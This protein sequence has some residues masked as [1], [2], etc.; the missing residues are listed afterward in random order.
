MTTM[1]AT[2]NRV[3]LRGVVASFALLA[4]GIVSVR[5]A[6]AQVSGI[7]YSVTPSGNWMIWNKDSGLDKGYLYGGSLG[8][9]FG[10]YVELNAQYMRSQDVETRLGRTT[11]F[12][13]LDNLP[14][15][16]NGVLAPRNVDLE[17][18]GGNIQFNLGGG[19]LIPY[20]SAGAGVLRFSPDDRDGNEQIYI[21]GGAGF[22]ANV[23]GRV[24]LKVGVENMWYRQ[25]LANMYLS[26]GD[27]TALG[28]AR[29]DFE[30]EEVGNWAV[31]AGL[32]LYLGGRNPRTMSDLDRAL[33]RQFSGGF[34][35][36]SLIVEPEVGM[37][38]FNR[39]LPYR[40]EQRIAGGSAG[41]DFGPYV[42]IR[43]FYWRGL[44]EDE[45]TK[46]DKFAM[47]GGQMKFRLNDAAT[48][49]VPFI[50]IG[51]GY[52]D[53]NNEYTG[54]PGR[55]PSDQPFAM[56]GGGVELRLSD[57]VKLHGTVRGI[58]I[59]DDDIEELATTDKIHN[60]WMY[61]AGISFALGNK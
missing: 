1:M 32:S 48:G 40:K 61:S 58:L 6:Q 39:N 49:V 50:D 30:D 25:N 51:A 24:S 8:I 7:S 22:N 21:T 35:G 27:L 43:G 37:I 59:S 53:V 23:N 4:V 17:R 31:T 60:S 9:G 45:W 16:E 20:V 29:G 13:D 5:P 28:M 54:R 19:S 15:L 41:F 47:Y 55:T 2:L 57:Y 26:N 34:S 46:F 52:L 36:I 3:H 38:E 10:R 18:I 12:K 33:Q 11:Y 42:G 56:G 44:E 14:A